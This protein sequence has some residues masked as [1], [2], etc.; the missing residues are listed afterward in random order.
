MGLVILRDGYGTLLDAVLSYIIIWPLR[1]VGE[2][3]Q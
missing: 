1:T 3:G 2:E